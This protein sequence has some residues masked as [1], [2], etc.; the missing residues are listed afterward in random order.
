MRA[1]K[2]RR[3]IVLTGFWD[4]TGR[5]L[6]DFCW[7]LRL[8]LD[9]W[10]GANWEQRGYNVHSFYSY[11]RSGLFEVAYRKVWRD[12]WNIVPRLEPVAVIGFGV[13]PGDWVVEEYARNLDRWGDDGTAVGQ[14]DPNPPDGGRP[15]GY[16]RISTL[17]GEAIVQAIRSQTTLDA[18]VHGDVGMGAF[19][20]EYMAYLAMWYQEQT[21][22]RTADRRCEMTGFIHVGAGVS[23]SDATEATKITVCEVIESLGDD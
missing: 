14:P 12:F 23:L 18:R 3:N 7:D 19:I 13:G 11:L 8:N 22:R 5:M 15:A 2:Q 17:P 16:V 20:C 10:K 9:G 6:K 1:G 4:P 21:Q